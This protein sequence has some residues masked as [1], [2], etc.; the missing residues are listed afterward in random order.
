MQ[1]RHVCLHLHYYFYQLVNY[2]LEGNKL[3]ATT[4]QQST[5]GKG[6]VATLC[7]NRMSFLANQTTPG[8]LCFLWL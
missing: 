5:N 2:H 3:S 1:K 4:F 8:F 6:I 7:V